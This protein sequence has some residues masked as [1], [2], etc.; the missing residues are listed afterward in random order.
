MK[1]YLKEDKKAKSK[2][3]FFKKEITVFDEKFLSFLEKNY[4]KYKKDIRICMHMN[5]SDKHH[6]MVLLNQKKNFYSKWL[7]NEKKGSL[8]HK[9]LDR[10]ET[11][12]VI[13]GKMAVVLFNNHGT[14]KYT[15]VLN[16]NSIFRTPINTFHTQIPLTKYVIFHESRTGPLPKYGHCIFPSWMKKFKNNKKEVTKFHEQVKTRIGL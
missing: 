10:G 9:H 14:I 13:K 1:N 5:T 3:F 16:Q 12:H 6:D 2:A 4:S 15:C 11:Y 7:K 8:P